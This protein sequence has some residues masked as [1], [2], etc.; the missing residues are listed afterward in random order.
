MRTRAG[1]TMRLWR[2]I[3]V[4]AFGAFVAACGGQG[5]GGDSR[6]ERPRDDGS[7]DATYTAAGDAELQHL[8]LTVWELKSGGQP[9]V[10]LALL[11]GSDRHEIATVKGGQIKGSGSA[12]VQP[13]GAAGTL[14]V[15]GKD[16][17]GNQP[18]VGVNCA[19]FTEPIAEGG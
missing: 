18:L 12:T 15:T 5:Q 4:A 11:T 1:P 7:P 8:N 13:A 16:E 17:D 14:S 2:L 3:S 6:T 19:R 10:T 9:Q